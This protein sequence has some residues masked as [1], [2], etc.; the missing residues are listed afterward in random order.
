MSMFQDGA[1]S[2]LDEDDPVI[3]ILVIFDYEI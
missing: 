1:T 3:S 2:S